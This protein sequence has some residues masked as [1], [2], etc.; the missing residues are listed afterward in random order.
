MIDVRRDD[1]ASARHLLAH[2]LGAHALPHRHELHLGGDLAAP[3]V[4]HLGH[5]PARLGPQAPAAARAG[6]DVVAGE[7]PVAAQRRQ[8]LLHVGRVRRV[9]VGSARVVEMQPFAVG[10]GHLAHGHAHRGIG[11]GQIDLAAGHARPPFAGITQVRFV[12]VGSVPAALSARA[13]ELPRGNGWRNAT[14]KG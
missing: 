10:E 4:V 14:S 8:A 1:G 3:G 9:G 6:L 7:D 11:S 2:H 12:A 5:P 13:T